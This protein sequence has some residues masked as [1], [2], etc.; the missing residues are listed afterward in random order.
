MTADPDDTGHPEDRTEI[1]S[2][3][4]PSGT[5]AESPVEETAL[6]QRHAPV[7][8]TAPSRREEVGERT[9]RSG[10]AGR[11]APLIPPAPELPGASRS[12]Q[13]PDLS[14]APYGPRPD[15][16]VRAARTAPAART[17]Q[18][19]NDPEAGAARR[20]RRAR[21]RAAIV[22]LASTVV[23]A[24]IVLGIIAMLVVPA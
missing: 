10:D 19:I 11:S 7:E 6:S 2:R 8:S 9:I 17:P 23:L 18:E 22:V 21:I 15:T 1:S 3:R 16:A 24:A 13:A 4:L 12:A 20:R 14:S 5:A